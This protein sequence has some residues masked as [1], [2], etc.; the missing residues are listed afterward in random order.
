M[1]R[2]EVQA[3]LLTLHERD[4]RWRS[5][6]ADPRAWERRVDAW[7]TD[8]ARYDAADIRRV[9]DHARQAGRMDLV[10]TSWLRRQCVARLRSLAAVERTRIDCEDCARMGGLQLCERHVRIG[11]ENIA[12]IRAARGWPTP[13]EQAAAEA[14]K[15][16]YSPVTEER[17]DTDD[18]A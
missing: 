4:G 16:R 9:I 15:V 12:A 6:E 3:L 13:A 14:A 17:H 11:R 5:P 8:L 7:T 2:S 18:R 10:T 1:T